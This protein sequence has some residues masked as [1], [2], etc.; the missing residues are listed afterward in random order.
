MKR[1]NDQMEAVLEAYRALHPPHIEKLTPELAR[2]VPLIDRAA[3]AVYGQ[4][5]TKRAL[6]PLPIPVGN[7]EHVTLAGAEG[8]EILARVYTPRGDTPT[9]GWP[10]LLYFHGGGWVLGTL[11]T[12]DSSCRALCEAAQCVVVSVHYRQAPEHPWPAAADDAFSAYR[13]LLAHAGAVG[14]SMGRIAVAGESAGGNLAAVVTLL[15]REQ[16]LPQ[17]VHQL[18]IYPVTDLEGG[19]SSPSAAE[20]VAA[21]PLSTSMLHWFYA[22]YVPEGVDRRHPHISPLHAKSL[23][24]L[25]PATIILA[26]LDPLRSD[27]ERYAARL[28][29]AGVR[30][31]LTTFEGVTHEFFGMGS[32]VNEAASAVALAAKNLRDAFATPLI[33]T[34]PIEMPLALAT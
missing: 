30:V 23:A 8:Q 28:D 24:G 33:A 18:L 4:H 12:Y 26:E 2:Q 3:V 11:D 34:P 10:V 21:E 5:F 20:H 6:L 25:A 22:H 32:V 15:A 29:N 17:P 13:W 7:V 14:G 19:T 27:G 31:S 9:E 16:N 1:P